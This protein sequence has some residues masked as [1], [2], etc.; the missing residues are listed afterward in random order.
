MRPRARDSC[1]IDAR[2]AMEPLS[3]FRIIDIHLG[4]L[5]LHHRPGHHF[6]GSQRAVR[7]EL[8]S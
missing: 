7:V 6:E 3:K 5:R 2:I 8:R 1:P 4:R